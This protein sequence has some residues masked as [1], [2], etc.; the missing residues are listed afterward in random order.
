MIIRL[1]I[2]LQRLYIRNI[3]YT[4][5]LPSYLEYQV[6]T[7]PFGKRNLDTS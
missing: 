6:D 5:S 4:L 3:P 2:D 7:T 1:A